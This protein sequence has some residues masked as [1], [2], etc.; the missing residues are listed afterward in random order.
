VRYLGF[1]TTEHGREYD[2]RAKG[3]ANES[4][5][6]VVLITH[7]TFS[8]RWARFQDG[9]GLCSEKLRRELAADPDLCPDDRLELARHELVELPGRARARAR[10]EEAA[11][12]GHLQLSLLPPALRL[13]PQVRSLANRPTCAMMRP[14]P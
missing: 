12:L 13:G 6:L 3:A 8:A 14:S 4:R 10:E 9:P 7:E 11:I 1:R 2:M 5:L